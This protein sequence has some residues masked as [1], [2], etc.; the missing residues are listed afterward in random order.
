M[1]WHRSGL[2]ASW[3]FMEE[4]VEKTND[5]DDLEKHSERKWGAMVVI[6]SLQF[7]PAVIT[8]A[9]RE[10]T[11]NSEE[12]LLCGSSEPTSH[13]NMLHIALAGVNN[14]MSLLQDRYKKH[15]YLKSSSIVAPCFNAFMHVE[16]EY[17]IHL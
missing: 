15:L 2:I 7:L 4:H 8:A 11:Q 3:E 12:T 10:T 14:Q 5:S 17:F 1:Q 6:K 9:L 16:L 13:G